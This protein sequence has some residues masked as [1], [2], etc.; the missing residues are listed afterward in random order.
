[1]TLQ[2]VDLNVDTDKGY[3]IQLSS[4]T[5]I[6]DAYS[7]VENPSGWGVFLGSNA[8]IYQGKTADLYVYGSISSKY[9]AIA[10]N[11]TNDAV[12]TNIYIYEGATVTSDSSQSVPAIFHPQ[13]GTLNISG[14]TISGYCGIEIIGGTL[15]I[16]GGTILGTHDDTDYRSGTA[17]GNGAYVNGAAIDVYAGSSGYSTVTVN[18]S[19]GTIQSTY[20]YALWADS[21]SSAA[22][23]A[24][25]NI[26]GGTFSGV[27]TNDSKKLEKIN[28]ASSSVDGDYAVSNA[29]I[30]WVTIN[31][32]RTD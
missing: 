21:L 17:S 32:T 22:Y 12:F 24:T 3:A 15:N 6:I 26:S 31:D 11:G 20:C 13:E 5:A 1:M 10:G 7:S 30:S 23:T 9:Q 27:T 29:G 2:N 8:S 19:G 16:S 28:Q 14:G 4:G 25:I 18:I